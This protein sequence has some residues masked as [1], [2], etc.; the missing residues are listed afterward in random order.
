VPDRVSIEE[1]IIYNH[2]L[3]ILKLLELG[4]PWDAIHNLEESEIAVILGLHLATE[5]RREDQEAAAQRQSGHMNL[6]G[7]R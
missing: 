4:I 5:Q 2:W 1:A 6:K 3:V 7:R